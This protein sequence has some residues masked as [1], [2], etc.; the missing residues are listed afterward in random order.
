MVRGSRRGWVLGDVD[1][2]NSHVEVVSNGQSEGGGGRWV[3]GQV[4]ACEGGVD[5]AVRFVCFVGIYGSLICM[6]GTVQA[7]G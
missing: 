5:G 6:R 7:D 3:P 4:V 2:W 1:I